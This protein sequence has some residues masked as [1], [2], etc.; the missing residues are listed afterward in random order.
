MH[1][2]T[3]AEGGEKIGKRHGGK[4]KRG[5]NRSVAVQRALYSL[6]HPCSISKSTDSSHLSLWPWT[7]SE[8][9]SAQVEGCSDGQLHNLSPT[10][11]LAFSDSIMTVRE[12]KKKKP[13]TKLIMV[14]GEKRNWKCTEHSKVTSW[15]CRKLKTASSGNIRAFTCRNGTRTTASL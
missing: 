7:L 5:Q 9:S 11:T 10:W 14:R 6:R 4:C 2:Q 12:G 8:H 15:H 3:K 1:V 13:W